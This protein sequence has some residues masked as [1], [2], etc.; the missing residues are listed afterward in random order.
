[1]KTK[2][3]SVSPH[4]VAGGEDTGIRLGKC[5]TLQSLNDSRIKINTRHRDLAN[6]GKNILLV[7]FYISKKTIYE[8]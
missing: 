6:V 8:Y 5:F 2:P 7:S 1:M 3:R 4:S